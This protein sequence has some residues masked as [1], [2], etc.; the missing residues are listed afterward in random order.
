MPLRAAMS[1]TAV[2][3]AWASVESAATARQKDSIGPPGACT[4]SAIASAVP[5]LWTVWGV[6][7]V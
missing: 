1:S 7:S 5:S 6:P 3:S 2:M 4:T